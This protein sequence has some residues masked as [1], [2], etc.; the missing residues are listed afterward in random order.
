[1]NYILLSHK[2]EGGGIQAVVR[3]Q[4]ELLSKAGKNVY[5]VC[6]K[7]VVTQKD[8]VFKVVQIP[9]HTWSGRRQLKELFNSLRNL[10]VLAHSFDAYWAMFWLSQYR[11]VT[12]NFVHVDYYAMYY[13]ENDFF[14]KL[15][16]TGLDTILRTQRHVKM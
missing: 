14:K 16:R 11:E 6:N 3:A 15:E 2:L 12:Y 7:Q 1:M 8:Y 5:V 10:R 13:K 9:F 4:A